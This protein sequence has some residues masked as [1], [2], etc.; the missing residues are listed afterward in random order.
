MRVIV[1]NCPQ[2]PMIQ[3]C[4]ADI[5]GYDWVPWCEPSMANPLVDIRVVGTDHIESVFLSDCRPVPR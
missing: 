1:V 3:G 2:Q 5:I 4:E